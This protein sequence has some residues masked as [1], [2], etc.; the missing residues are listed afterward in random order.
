M[1]NI[2]F[3]NKEAPDVAS[4]LL[5]RA[6]Y[7]S[8][9][10]E[11]N[12][13][14]QKLRDMYCAYYGL[15]H[16]DQTGDRGHKIT[17]SGEQ[18]ELVNIPINHFRNIASH[19]LTMTTANRP[20]FEARA[21]NTDYK[22]LVQS[23]LANSILDYYLREKRIENIFKRATELAIIMGSGFV[24]MDWNATS[25]EMYDRDIETG[26]PMYNGDIEFKT[27]SVFDV[28]CDT[29]K[30]SWDMDWVVT[31]TYKNKYDLAAKYPE[32][33]NKIIELQTKSDIDNLRI[34]FYASNDK[35]DDI[36]IY[37][38][39]HKKTDAV[40]SG[41]YILFLSSDIILH[42]NPLPYRMIPVFR[43]SAGEILGTPYGY[44]PM[45]DILPIQEAI[46]TLYSTVLTNQSAFGVQNVWIKRGSDI[47]VSSLSGGLNIIES[48]EQPVP[49]NLTSTPKEI[50]DFI[51]ILERVAETISGV[52]SVTRGNPEASL[53]SGTALALVQ[54]MSLQFLSGL[55]QS[56]V[57]L[58]EDVG[59]AIVKFLQDFGTAP[60]V[61]AIAGKNNRH[62]IK[63]FTSNDISNISRVSIDVGNPLARSTAGRVQIAEN[64]LQYQ[65]LK[66]PQQYFTIINTGNLDAVTDD[67]QYSQFL[68]H[69]ENER[70]TEGEIPPALYSD[71]HKSH[72]MGHRQVLDDPDLR[73]DYGLIERVRQ[74]M[75]QHIN[76][77][78]TVNP[79]LLVLFNQ[80]PLQ[81]TGA[82]P[83][84]EILQS[85]E[86]GVVAGEQQI[87]NME[88]S[89]PV[90]IPQ[91]SDVDA[92]LLPNPE[93]QQ[94]AMGNVKV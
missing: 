47:N 92:N 88:T 83:N 57:Q 21:I 61:V 15:H 10:L 28:L 81:P 25:G 14:F 59:S 68:I 18:G 65:L 54:S 1:E 85:P 5:E 29:S 71:D 49:I 30:E 76:L 60:R 52:S 9:N 39:Y 46:N 55:Q 86:S 7:W 50:F 82:P 17:F 91:P 63:Q 84:A 27:L 26:L 31:R 70:L 33:A 66:N 42:D 19:M 2:Y 20:S 75:N 73:K 8:T 38:F 34:G 22:S 37:E 13:L 90:N 35:T 77:L 53:R 24:K 23:K 41:R 6:Q 36:P 78:K 4:I 94:A 32:Y 72:I 64:L 69:E 58:V 51:A 43:I 93:L 11:T 16:T 74:H 62:R 87:Q 80:Q 12:G 40:E 56:Y 48:L 79:E 67:E 89:E 3:A 45:F 44:S